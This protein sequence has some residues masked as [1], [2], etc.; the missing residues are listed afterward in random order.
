M[1]RTVRWA[2]LLALALCGCSRV[3]GER[4]D[5]TIREQERALDPFAEVEVANAIRVRIAP[6]PERVV[7]RGD[8]NLLPRLLTTVH[9]GRLTIRMEGRTRPSRPPE[10][11]LRSPWLRAI[12]ARG[13]SAVTADGV[14]GDAEEK[15]LRLSASG[16][17]Q[18]TARGGCVRLAAE[19]SGASV[20]DANDLLAQEA[21]ARATGA[22]T[23]K[24]FAA[25]S[26]EVTA[27]GASTVRVA[28]HPKN[29]RRESS[30]G[31]SIDVE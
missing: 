9:D 28:G 15:G 23:V 20:V 6:G 18:V 25:R 21:R 14:T 5:G 31:S 29:V 11:E 2:A 27:S 8:E 7:V 22:S 26:V 10:V 3:R 16:A 1:R 12:D 30:G 4:G 19:A 24:L 13:A 17:S